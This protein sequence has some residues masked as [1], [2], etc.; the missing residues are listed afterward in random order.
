MI[1]DNNLV[2]VLLDNLSHYTQLAKAK[3]TEAN[4]D[5]DRKKLQLVNSKYSHHEEVDERLQFLKYI[6]QVA[7]DYQI[8]K[9]ELGRIYNLL[10]N[11]ANNVL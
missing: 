9:V 5:A 3:V 11:P 7:T 8:S 4:K 1:K 2:N 6:A 10:S